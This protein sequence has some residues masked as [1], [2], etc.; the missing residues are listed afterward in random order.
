MNP[1]AGDAA[2]AVRALSAGGVDVAIEAVG[3]PETIA[4]GFSLLRRGG[5]LCLIG[6][7]SA[8]AALPADRTMFFEY[9]VV[10]SLGCRPVDYPRVV[11]MVES[12]TVGLEGVVTGR[13]PLD[14]IGEAADRLRRGEGLRTVIVPR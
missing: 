11:R 6:Y 7:S 13:L 10:G 8:P 4:L 12:G 14:R 3:R 1:G 5:R 9:T 2:K